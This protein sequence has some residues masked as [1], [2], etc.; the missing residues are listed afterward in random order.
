MLDWN[1][2]LVEIVRERIGR[3]LKLDSIVGG[4]LWKGS[5]CSSSIHGIGGTVGTI[6]TD[7]DRLLALETA[8]T[9]WA[10]WV[11][12][13]IDPTKT[14]LFFQGIS[15]SHYNGSLWNEP[16][17]KSYVGQKQPVFGLT[18]TG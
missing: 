1:V 3:V 10:G 13:N 15:P 17:A 16:S 11:D 14:K 5:T 7:M 4:K 2:Y 6:S 9:T 12:S 8:L 18:Y